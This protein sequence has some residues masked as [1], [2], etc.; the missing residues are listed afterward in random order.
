MCRWWRTYIHGRSCHVSPAQ[1]DVE[2]QKPPGSSSVKLAV[3]APRMALFNRP[4]IDGAEDVVRLVRRHLDVQAVHGCRAAS[5]QSPGP[6]I[7]KRR[8]RPCAAGPCFLFGSLYAF[9]CPISQGLVEPVWGSNGSDRQRSSRLAQHGMFV[10]HHVWRWSVNADWLN[11]RRS[12]STQ[13]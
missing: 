2:V 11:G 7:V 12:Q 9:C 10:F 13:V 8:R 4:L 1:M 3:Q 6:G 5:R